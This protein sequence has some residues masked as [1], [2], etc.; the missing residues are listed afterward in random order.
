MAI[1]MGI[2][3]IGANTALFKR[4]FRWIMTLSKGTEPNN[5]GQFPTSADKPET[6]WYCK[7][8]KRPTLTFEDTA[9][10]F[11]HEKHHL[12]GKSSWEDLNLTIYDVHIM[13]N[14]H[15]SDLILAQWL[16]RVWYF[17]GD[18][19]VE[20]QGYNWLDMGDIDNEYKQDI[21]LY[22]LD[23]HGG[24]LETWYIIGAWPKSTNFGDLD[25][26]SSDTVDAAVTCAFDRAKF[27]LGPGQNVSL[28]SHNH[29]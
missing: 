17:S 14:D 1:S 25:M 8:S 13:D 27:V 24:V 9:I 23:G 2:G 21:T 22:M 3:D 26:A 7:V 4:K 6:M 16:S 20:T 11:L 10:H 18:S 5:A 29:A 12:S 19:N 15:G 28:Q